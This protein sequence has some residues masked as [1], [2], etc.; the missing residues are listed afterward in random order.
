MELV[1]GPLIME[2]FQEPFR[3]QIE[4]KNTQEGRIH[5]GQ[6]E[7]MSIVDNKLLIVLAWLA[8]GKYFPPVPV[9]WIVDSRRQYTVDVGGC[10]CYAVY[11]D[12][13]SFF[14]YDEG[15]Y[16]FLHTPDEIILDP[17]KVR[18]LTSS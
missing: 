6:I 16:V 3:R 4:I 13:F 18:G 5:I 17:L 9:E 10:F 12:R 1:N 14:S 7:T 15:D 2:Y 11:N 8:R